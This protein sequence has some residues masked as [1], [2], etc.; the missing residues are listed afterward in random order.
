METSA[1]GMDAVLAATDTITSLLSKVW[2]VMTANPLL[3][4]ILASGLL[5]IGLA[6]FRKV[7]RTA[8]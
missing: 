1:T 6:V 2:S 3:T 8:R 5:S 4:V 7:K